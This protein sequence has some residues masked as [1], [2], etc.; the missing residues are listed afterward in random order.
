VSNIQKMECGNRRCS[1]DLL[2]CDV[3]ESISVN[4]SVD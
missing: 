4:L 1:S 2:L 3:D